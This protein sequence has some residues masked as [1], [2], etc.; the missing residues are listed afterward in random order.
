MTI[1]AEK[2]DIIARI[3]AVPPE[4]LEYSRI[5][6]VIAG[7]GAGKSVLITE[8]ARLA[9]DRSILFLSK[10]RNIAD[11]ARLSLP[12]SVRVQTLYSQALS[13]VDHRYRG[14]IKRQ[15]GRVWSRVPIQAILA[16]GYVA[17]PREAAVARSAVEHWIYSTRPIPDE[18]DIPSDVREELSKEGLARIVQGARAVATSQG[19]PDTDTI[20][21]TYD[22]IIREWA[23]ARGVVRLHDSDSG[24]SKELDPLSG[25]SLVVLEEA[26]DCPP[27]VYS[28]LKR[29]RISLLML[30][31]PYQSLRAF[32]AD[33]EAQLPFLGGITES[34]DSETMTLDGSFRFGDPIA[35][36]LNALTHYVA[37]DADRDRLKGLGKSSVFTPDRRGHMERMGFHY[38]YI[39]RSL[40]TVLREAVRLASQGAD[41]A[42]VDGIWSYSILAFRD[43]MAIGMRE[44]G[45]DPDATPT[46]Q[47]HLRGLATLE[48]AHQ[49]FTSQRDNHHLA[50][51]ELCMELQ[52]HM[53]NYLK[54]IDQ[55]IHQD[56]LRQEALKRNW[57]SAPSRHVTMTTTT[58]AKGS[59]FD[60]VVLSDD[61]VPPGLLK[62]GAMS[63]QR[64]ASLHHL[65]TAISRAKYEVVIPAGLVEWITQM[66][67]GHSRPALAMNQL[68]PEERV[69]TPLWHPEFGPSPQILLEMVPDNR[70]RRAADTVTHF[71]PR[72]RGDPAG[73]VKRA[74][75]EEL[76]RQKKGRPSGPS[77]LRAVLKGDRA[78]DE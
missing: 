31:D 30:G 65:Y 6:R 60:R 16:S 49:H 48:D 1:A 75:E 42:W 9:A 64:Q 51:V 27:I 34:K 26:Q 59:E 18:S 43:L 67:F 29:Q 12:K 20:P 11:R 68:T 71:K 50:L 19:N 78:K 47:R 69:E 77:A 8:L 22:F 56:S 13:F 63:P 37:G 66:G 2:R 72:F 52:G 10:S 15:G 58:R 17:T 3:M 46:Y 54:V 4:E 24:E 40:S 62:S 21:L 76:S 36:L 57:R 33:E 44:A 14:K 25:A 23:S 74:F 28:F 41:L 38:A 7:A 35:S 70:L 55:M 73:A 39:G 5:F 32:S 53:A 45:I 61:L